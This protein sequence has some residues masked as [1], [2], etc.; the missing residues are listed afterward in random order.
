MLNVIE[1]SEKDANSVGSIH[2]PASWKWSLMEVPSRV[3]KQMHGRKEASLFMS[4][5]K[6]QWHRSQGESHFQRAPQNWWLWTWASIKHDF[7]QPCLEAFEYIWH[8]GTKVP[9]SPSLF[10]WLHK[11]K[12]IR[13]HK[14]NHIGGW[15]SPDFQLHH[16]WLCELKRKNPNR[17]ELVLGCSS[18]DVWYHK[19]PEWGWYQK[20]SRLRMIST[21]IVEQCLPTNPNYTTSYYPLLKF[22]YKWRLLITF[23]P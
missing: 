10:R 4:E 7:K 3:V 6:A 17:F 19:N 9:S 20:K 5:S 2:V 21:L 8:F 16:L 23:F 22:L 1:V 14:R 11:H 13:D 15:T 18:E 12:S